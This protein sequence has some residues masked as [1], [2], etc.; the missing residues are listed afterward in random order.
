LRHLA[1]DRRYELAVRLARLKPLIESLEA[2]CTA[3]TAE[4]QHVQ[5]RDRRN[6]ASLATHP[7]S[8]TLRFMPPTEIE[9]LLARL[10]K[11]TQVAASLELQG[12]YSAESLKNFELVAAE[13]ETIRARLQMLQRPPI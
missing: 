5:S 1:P 4:L 11:L 10:A 9:F 7:K 2:E 8:F 12:R 3:R 13:I 6:Q